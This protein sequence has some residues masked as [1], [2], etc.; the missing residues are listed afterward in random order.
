VEWSPEL[1]TVI[2]RLKKLGPQIRPT[3][4]CNLEG[5]AFTS[6]GFRSNWHRLMTKTMTPGE[7]G[8][9][10]AL[11]E[12]FTFHDLRAKSASDDDFD[13][14]TERLAHDDPRT[15]QRVYRRKPRRARP[16]A[17]ILDASGD[18]GQ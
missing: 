14:A 8:E 2:D 1:R 7:K 12:R 3:L 18:I 4:L 16:G 11:A 13:V 17:K 10:P 5:K 6:D 9:P 15:T